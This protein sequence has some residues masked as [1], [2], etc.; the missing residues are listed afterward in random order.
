VKQPCSA[1]V[2]CASFVHSVAMCWHSGLIMRHS[3]ATLAAKEYELRAV[4]DAHAATS[5]RLHAIEEQSRAD[6]TTLSLSDAAKLRQDNAAYVEE[7]IE[8][9]EE[10][11]IT[12][13]SLDASMATSAQLKGELQ[14]F[15]DQRNLLFRKHVAEVSQARGEAAR[16]RSKCDEAAERA[17]TAAKEAE[18]YKA[19]LRRLEKGDDVKQSATERVMLKLR[20]DRVRSAGQ[21]QPCRLPQLH[22]VVA[23]ALTYAS[24]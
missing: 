23:E 2:Q 13:R 14:G 10:L 6:A 16:A 24:T 4:Q 15:V 7:L 5:G 3:Q 19:E 18:A 1:S 21:A 22:D 17:A 8:T 20:L 9:V 12:K 11:N